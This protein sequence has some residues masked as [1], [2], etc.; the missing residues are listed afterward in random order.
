MNNPSN[1][2]TEKKILLYFIFFVGRRE[3]EEKKGM[4]LFLE[5]G[6]NL[7][8]IPDTWHRTKMYNLPI[9]STCTNKTKI[10]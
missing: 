9:Y 6:E 10:N 5:E 7:L 3:R 2:K 4:G 8:H 1:L